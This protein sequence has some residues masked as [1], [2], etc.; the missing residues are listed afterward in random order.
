MLYTLWALFA[1]LWRD[2]RNGTSSHREAASSFASPLLVFVAAVLF[3]LMSILVVDLHLDELQ[4]LGLA[5]G[6]EQINPVFISP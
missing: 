3:S 6:T 4:A 2:S 5:G 1:P